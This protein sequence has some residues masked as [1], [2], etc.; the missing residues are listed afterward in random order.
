MLDLIEFEYRRSARFERYGRYAGLRR[1]V[2]QR[3]EC[4]RTVQDHHAAQA[5]RQRHDV[6]IAKVRA[7]LRQV[8]PFERA[9]MQID[10]RVAM[11]D[12]VDE[13]RMCDACRGASGRVAGEIAIQVAAIRQVARAAPEALYVY[14]R[15]ADDRAG[16]FVRV[17]IVQHPAHHF[18]AVELV[19]V[20]GRGEA[21]VRA[22]Q[23]AVDGQ[24]RGRYRDTLEKLGCG[25]RQSHRR[26]WR[27]LRSQQPQRFRES[28]RRRDGFR[29]RYVMRMTRQGLD[30]FLDRGGNIAGT[31]IGIFCRIVTDV[32]AVAGRVDGDLARR[33]PAADAR[34]QHADGERKQGH[35]EGV[36]SHYRE[37][38]SGSAVARRF[39]AA[40][41]AH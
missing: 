31:R 35:F 20:H 18:D 30:K 28:F 27:N 10:E 1:C 33:G 9:R 23:C 40:G 17:D 13:K 11:C 24:D 4:R 26:A 19:A 14:D 15:H 12:D 39:A 5:L 41:K 3:A 32:G 22:R 38:A 21:Q 16:Q 36:N 29:E 34:Q 37:R 6:R 7:N 8:R 2:P 25:P